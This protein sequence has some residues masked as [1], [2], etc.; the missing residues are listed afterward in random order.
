MCGYLA[1]TYVLVFL[2]SFLELSF[3]KKSLINNNSLK[4]C[5]GLFPVALGIITTYFEPHSNADLYYQFY[6]I[7]LLKDVPFFSFLKSMFGDAMWGENLIFWAFSRFDNVEFYPFFFTTLVIGITLALGLKNCGNY[8]PARIVVISLLIYFAGNDLSSVFGGVRNKFV[9]GVIVWC[10]Y[11]II[12]EK[13]KKIPY[14]AAITFC[15]FV[16]VS[17]IMTLMIACLAVVLKG[18][19][20]VA[21]IFIPLLYSVVL[22]AIE[23][24]GNST[25]QFFAIKI[26]FYFEDY[27]KL[28]FK[29][30]LGSGV[31]LVMILIALSLINKETLT[32]GELKYL[33]VVE[34]FALFGI[35][36]LNAPHIMTRQIGLCCCAMLPLLGKI[37]I[38]KR[39][40]KSYIL[41]CSGIVAIII[42]YIYGFLTLTEAYMFKLI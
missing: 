21:F 26:K 20:K 39:R 10:L 17:V 4:I 5:I 14:F 29:M 38:D 25:V 22:N 24:I 32:D 7:K 9:N 42:N 28:S 40:I 18:K 41:L 34:G 12:V 19:K 23:K 36:C 3:K 31:L 16:H 13:R 35:G 27:Y 11:K 15:C 1:L 37:V 8:I 2:I 33:G 30:L 6:R